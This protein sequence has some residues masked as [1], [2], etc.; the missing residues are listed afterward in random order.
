MLFN[1]KQL[2]FICGCASWHVRVK[3]PTRDRTLSLC[4][5]HSPHGSSLSQ[6]TVLPR[7]TW[8]LSSDKDPAG[9]WL[10]GSLSADTSDPNES[11][12]PP[13]GP[14]HSND[15]QSSPTQG[16]APVK[17]GNFPVRPK[18]SCASIKELSTDSGTLGFLMSQSDSL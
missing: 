9:R 10:E 3:P 11:K 1:F 17:T 12:D 15:M 8:G 16:N 2:L 7:R 14:L 18:C 13:A 5:L 4:R 6:E